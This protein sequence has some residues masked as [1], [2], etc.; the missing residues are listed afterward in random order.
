MVIQLKIKTDLVQMIVYWYIKNK[1]PM[2]CI[3]D[4]S[5]K[6]AYKILKGKDMSIKSLP[7][8]G[9]RGLREK[10]IVP[11]DFK[12]SIKINE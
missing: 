7:G 5:L 4:I 12:M 3:E 8:Y 9:S 10:D 2:S 11:Y 6:D 1:L